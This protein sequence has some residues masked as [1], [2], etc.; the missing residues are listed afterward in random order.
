VDISEED[1]KYT[2]L[3]LGDLSNGNVKKIPDLDSNR[4]YPNPSYPTSQKPF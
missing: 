1:R 3:T 2:H 4:F